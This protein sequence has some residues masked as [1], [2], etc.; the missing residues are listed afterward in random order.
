M[1]KKESLKLAENSHKSHEM[2]QLHEIVSN[3]DTNDQCCEYLKVTVIFNAES[4]EFS[5][6]MNRVASN[7][8]YGFTQS[9]RAS[10]RPIPD[11]TPD[12]RNSLRYIF[13]KLLRTL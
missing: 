6:I 7:E 5:L 13:R 10:Y 3:H 4:I 9:F 12:F 2:T 1:N 8:Y 11:E